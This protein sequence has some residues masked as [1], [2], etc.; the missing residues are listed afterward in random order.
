MCAHKEERLLLE[1]GE[2][3]YFTQL[4]KKKQ[5]KNKGKEKI[6]P[7]TN[8]KESKCSFCKKKRT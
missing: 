7:K 3:V 5:G 4:G 1:E 2:K 6:N 8:M